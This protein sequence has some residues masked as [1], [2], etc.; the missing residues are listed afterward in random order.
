MPHYLKSSARSCPVQESALK[1]TPAVIQIFPH[2]WSRKVT[3][4]LLLPE[5]GQRRTQ[6]LFHS[7]QALASWDLCPLP[8]TLSHWVISHPSALGFPLHMVLSPSLSPASALLLAISAPHQLLAM[9]SL[10]NCVQA[11]APECH[12]SASGSEQMPN[13]FL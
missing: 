1:A 5:N 4:P 3:A 2:S 9:V 12:C 10:S 8:S 11:Q 6:F 7:R 13:F